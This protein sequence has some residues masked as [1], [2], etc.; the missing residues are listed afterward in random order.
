MKKTKIVYLNI[1]I[2]FLFALTNAAAQQR[3]AQK[4]KIDMD[5]VLVGAAPVLENA[6]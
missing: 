1:L 4:D 6:A 3:V 5:K 2:F